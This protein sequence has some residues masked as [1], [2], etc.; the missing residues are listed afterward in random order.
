VWELASGRIA[1]HREQGWLAMAGLA[2]VSV[3]ALA[4]YLA[5]INVH[6]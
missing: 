4:A 1:H 2:A 6:T 5:G 3:A